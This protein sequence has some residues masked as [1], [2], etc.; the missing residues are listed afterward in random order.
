ILRALPTDNPVF[1]KWFGWFVLL[2]IVLLVLVAVPGSFLS[3][4]KR[5]V[6]GLREKLPKKYDPA[7]DRSVAYVGYHTP[8]DEAGRD[9]RIFGVI[10]WIVQTLTLSAVSV[11]AFGIVLVLFVGLESI[12]GLSP[13]GSLL[14]RLGISAMG[15]VP[16]FRDR[17]I[18]LMDWLTYLPR[19]VWSDL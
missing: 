14:N 1:Q 18:L 11:L 6:V 15:D 19:L 7:G 8:G 3:W 2:G 10:T 9:L 13:R 17:F 4:L 5:E 12:L 16:E